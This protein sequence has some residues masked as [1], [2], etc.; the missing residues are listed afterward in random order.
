MNNNLLVIQLKINNFTQKTLDHSFISKTKIGT[1]DKKRFS[2]L[3]TF[4]LF[5][6]V[7]EVCNIKKKY[8]IPNKSGE[9]I[10]LPKTP[11]TPLSFP[12]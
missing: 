10:F 11:Y 1:L 7:E 3:V 2:I 9:I 8:W 6:T 5:L 12:K 4:S